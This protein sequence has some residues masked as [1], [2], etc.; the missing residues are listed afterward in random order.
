MAEYIQYSSQK[1][2]VFLNDIGN[3]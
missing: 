3:K 2:T 1:N